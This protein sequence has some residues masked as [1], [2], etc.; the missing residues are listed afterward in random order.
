[1]GRPCSWISRINIVKMV[2]LPKA[3]SKSQ[4]QFF[5]DRKIKPK[6]HMEV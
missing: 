3:P 1:M 4:H 2:T 6:I 5:T